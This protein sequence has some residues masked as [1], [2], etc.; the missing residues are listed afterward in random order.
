[1][2]LSVAA[3]VLVVAACGGSSSSSSS[4]VAKVGSE[5]ITKKQLDAALDYD[6]RHYPL[7]TFP[8]RG[9]AEYVLLRQQAIDFLVEQSRAHRADA[10]LGIDQQDRVLTHASFL[11]VTASVHVSDDEI[12]A[13]FQQHRKQLGHAHRAMDVGTASSIRSGLLSKR[14]RVVVGSFLADVKRRYPVAYAPGYAPVSTASVARR[15]WGTPA[16]KRCDLPAGSYSFVVARDHGCAT[17]TP[18]PG[19]NFPPYP[20]VDRS[21]PDWGFT[22]AE[23]RDGYMDYLA[24][25]GGSCADDPRLEGVQVLPRPRPPAPVKVSYLHL[26]GSATFKE[27]RFGFTLRYPRRLHLERLDYGSRV[28]TEGVEIANYPLA[29]V[30]EGRPLSRAA[31]DFTFAESE[32][33]LAPSPP[34]AHD[35]KFPLRMPDSALTSGSYS[36]TVAAG[37][38]KLWLTIRVGSAPSAQD[39][40]AIR[41]IVASIRF[42]ELRAGSF[43]PSGYYVLERASRYPVGSVTRVAAGIP[44]P[45]EGPGSGVLRSERFYLEHAAE[46][47]RTITWPNNLSRGYKECGVRFEPSRRQFTCGNGAVWDLDGQVVRNPD[48]A[49][50]ADDALYRESAPVSYDGFVLVHLPSH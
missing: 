9:S 39:L 36:T 2:G 38:T 28:T 22:S 23:A 32:G 16:H 26:A 41:A 7:A 43:T 49:R 11:K 18:I 40:A 27:R 48:P 20:L 29:P 37:A 8:R 46:G 12:E 15:I 3:V 19:K 4:Y 47:F 1:V 21:G 13:Y 24:D 25:T 42:P 45:S 10:K 30:P 31:I 5:P 44:L 33:G 35:T 14:Q 34:P 50:F 17:G 6:R